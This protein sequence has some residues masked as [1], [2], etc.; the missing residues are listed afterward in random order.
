MYQTLM[1]SNLQF[2]P[3][4]CYNLA[5]KKKVFPLFLGLFL[6]VGF[7]PAHAGSKTEQIGP[8]EVVI[9]QDTCLQ[10]V[11]HRPDPDVAYQPGMDVR[12]NDVVP[13]DLNAGQKVF[14]P[15][16]FIVDLDVFL[17]DALDIDLGLT[18]DKTE[19]SIVDV[20]FNTKTQEVLLNDQVLLSAKDTHITDLCQ[21]Y[22]GGLIGN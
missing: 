13:A 7:L 6:L 3:E 20:Q 12:G 18:G 22:Y 2:W 8:Q 14:I 16:Q 21:E 9:T 15:D 5:M 17:G 11:E 10:L 19:A 1:S 4:M